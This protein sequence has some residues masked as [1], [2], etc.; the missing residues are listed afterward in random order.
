MN[1]TV[2]TKLDTTLLSL[3]LSNYFYYVDFKS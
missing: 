3:F 2:L 1:N